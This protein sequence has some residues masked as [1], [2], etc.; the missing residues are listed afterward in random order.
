MVLD[1]EGRGK[2]FLRDGSPCYSDISGS[3]W[4]SLT[5][6][7]GVFL[8]DNWERKSPDFPEGSISRGTPVHLS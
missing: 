4:H 2:V 7:L 6:L 1:E 3:G 8:K 5:A